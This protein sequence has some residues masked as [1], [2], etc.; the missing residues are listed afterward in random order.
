MKKLLIVDRSEIRAS[1]LELALRDD[2]DVHTSMNIDTVRQVLKELR[3]DALILN[4]SFL[5]EAGPEIFED[6]FPNMPPVILM[7]TTSVDP[8]VVD[9]ALR[10]GAGCIMIIPSRI[11]CIKDRINEMYDFYAVPQNAID[12]HLHVLGV[13]TALTG[14]RCLSSAIDKYTREQTLLLKEIYPDIAR[15]CGLRD[16]RC[17]E[18]VIRTAIGNAWKQRNPRIWAQYFPL[19]KDGDISQPTNK[20]FISAVANRI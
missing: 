6:C 2:W 12:R 8:Y 16:A 19:N 11:A 15:E 14:Y 17:V 13:N 18:H 7:L 4:F 20:E 1:S 10:F 5:T 9:T 3:S